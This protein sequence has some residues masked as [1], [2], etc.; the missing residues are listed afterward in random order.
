MSLG[1]EQIPDSNAISFGHYD[2]HSVCV[3][4][5]NTNLESQ[6]DPDCHEI[7]FELPDKFPGPK[8]H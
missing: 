1:N 3:E 6:G 4:A 2:I 5:C 7:S 8:Y